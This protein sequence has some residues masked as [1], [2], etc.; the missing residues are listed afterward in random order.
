MGLEILLPFNLLSE[1][2]T[3]TVCCP[4]DAAMTRIPWLMDYA[5]LAAVVLVIYYGTLNPWGTVT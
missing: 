4:T 1:L 2:G 3:A 5:M